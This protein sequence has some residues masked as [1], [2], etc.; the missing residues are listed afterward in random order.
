VSAW[1]ANTLEVDRI[2][3]RLINA[4]VALH[5]SR[6]LVAVD[7]DAVT[8]QCAYTGAESELAADSV[9]L[10]TARQPNSGLYLGLEARIGE[11]DSAGVQSLRRIGD[12]DAPSTIAAAVYAGHKAGREFENDDADPALA[13]RRE[14]TALSDGFPI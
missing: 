8:V 4:G 1:T 2:Q 7:G 11:W 13:I 6:A 5:T 10:V 9:V 14:V 12:A 3:A